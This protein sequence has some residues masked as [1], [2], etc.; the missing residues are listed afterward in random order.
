MRRFLL[1]LLVV[2]MF[3]SLCAC[4]TKEDTSDFYYLRSEFLPGESD[5][6]IAA[7]SR[8]VSGERGFN[9]SLRLYLEGPVSDQFISPFPKGL[10]LLSTRQDGEV[11][12]IYLSSEFAELK[13][14]D[15][16]LAWACLAK[17]CLALTDAAQIQIISSTPDGNITYDVDMDQFALLDDAVSMAPNE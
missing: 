17:T 4:G 13:D 12:Q 14:V 16:T 9:Y 11:M 10:R 2:C 8:T 5:G 7:E 15:L 6:V 1:L 3:A